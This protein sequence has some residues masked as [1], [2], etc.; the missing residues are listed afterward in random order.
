MKE[1][2]LTRN[3]VTVVDDEDYGFLS[4][5]KW[6]FSCGYAVG[7]CNGKVC[8]M[9]RV[10]NKTPDGF[11]TDHINRDRLD[12][13]KCNLRTVRSQENKWNITIPRDNTSGF[14]GVSWHKVTKK[15]RACIRIN[16]KQKHLGYFDDE[17]KA[18]D[19]YQ[20]AVKTRDNLR[21]W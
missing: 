9:H 8:S 15:W 10:I 11:E 7:C 2:Q 1:I 17:R 12:N 19:T 13:R 16:G 20:D 14:M 21:E 4:Q 18:S 3:K 6:C 5:F